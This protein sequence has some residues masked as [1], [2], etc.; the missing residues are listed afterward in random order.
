[1]NATGAFD[2]GW[3]GQYQRPLEH[4]SGLLETIEMGAR[5]YVPG[6]GR[7]LEADPVEGGS[8]NAYEYCSGD[9]TNCNDLSG[10]LL[11]T[12]YLYTPSLQLISQVRGKWKTHSIGL[13]LPI[14]VYSRQTITSVWAGMFLYCR[15][16]YGRAG[17]RTNC[18]EAPMVTFRETVIHERKE[19][20][21]GLG[22]NGEPAFF[23]WF[24]A[25]K[26]VAVVYCC[27]REYETWT[28]NRTFIHARRYLYWPIL[29]PIQF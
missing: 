6:L 19:V 14:S 11:Y 26:T 17:W 9:A 25:V 29:L 15:S 16:G 23:S 3:L 22:Q 13:G 24:E 20:Y 12:P 18:F 4:Q 1:D 5:Q 7:F 27:K 28:I 21:V 10:Y 2:Y 8:A